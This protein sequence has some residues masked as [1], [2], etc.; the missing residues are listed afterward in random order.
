MH[1]QSNLV[2]LAVQNGVGRLHIGDGA[3]QAFVVAGEKGRG[4]GG[5]QADH[6]VFARNGRG[7]SGDLQRDL[8]QL[9]QIAVIAE[10]GKLHAVH[11][12]GTDYRID[13]ARPM[14]GYGIVEVLIP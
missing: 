12:N 10:K 4:K 6:L 14:H 9:A 1:P 3:R 7:K 13:L 2:L 11:E 8:R 5:T